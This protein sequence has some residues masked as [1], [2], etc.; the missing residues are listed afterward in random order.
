MQATEKS[1]AFTSKATS[2]SLSGT[3]QDE[4]AETVSAGPKKAVSQL[5]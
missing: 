4:N 3:T 1:G 5:T 2:V